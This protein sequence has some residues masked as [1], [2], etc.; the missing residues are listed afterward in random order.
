MGYCYRYDGTFPG[1]LCAV[2]DIYQYQE[3]PEL[4]LPSDDLTPTLYDERWITTDL[5]LAQ[6]VRRRLAQRLGQRGLLLVEEGFLTCAPDRELLLCRFIDLAL[7]SGKGAETRLDQPAVVELTKA[8]RHLQREC[9][10]L[11][12]F[13]RFSDYDGLLVGEI[14][15]KN[16]VLPILKVHF[17]DRLAGE[18][19][20][21]FDRTHGEALLHRPGETQIVPAQDFQPP[22]PGGEE[23]A[24]RALWR[25]FY[26]TIAIEGRLNPKLRQNHMPKRYW[27]HLTEFQN[28][29]APMS[30]LLNG[31]RCDDNAPAKAPF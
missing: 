9:E 6:R 27:K 13:V 2:R 10:L 15:P 16:R 30:P 3:P 23:R 21:L 19:F 12:G 24:Y 17:C 29:D 22:P 7:S 31:G 26:D 14:S 18:S 20:L 28:D 5:S 25:R 11:T 4:F 1:F 8:V